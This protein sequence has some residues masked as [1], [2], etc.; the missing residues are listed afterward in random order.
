M[1]P[2]KNKPQSGGT[3]E[4]NRPVEKLIEDGICSAG[5]AGW[6]VIKWVAPKAGR[7]FTKVAIRGGKAAASTPA[8]KFV[9]EAAVELAQG[10]GKAAMGLIKIHDAF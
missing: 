1:N 3:S 9:A 4:G 8:A 6:N 5:K 2:Q 10:S 7:I